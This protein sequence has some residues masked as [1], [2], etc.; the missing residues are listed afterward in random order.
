M[1]TDLIFFNSIMFIETDFLNNWTIPSQY[2]CDG[3]WLFPTLVIKDISETAK[4]LALIVDD[5]DAPVGNR[6]HYLM[7]NI[8]VSGTTL[9]MTTELENS[10]IVWMNSRGHTNRGGP[11]APNGTHRYFF[12][13][14]AL[15]SILDLQ[16]WFLKHE[17]LDLIDKHLVQKTEIVW[18]YA[19]K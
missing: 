17:L 4:S 15:D 14:Y 7:A 6:D 9:S 3:D 8:P 13:V 11:C 12:K 1:N 10:S 5:P 19:K 16:K 2:T 18:L